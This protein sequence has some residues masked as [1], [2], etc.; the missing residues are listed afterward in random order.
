MLLLLMCFGS[1][2][3]LGEHAASFLALMRGVP[4]LSSCVGAGLSLLGRYSGHIGLDVVLV[5]TTDFV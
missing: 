2:L 5:N 3:T 4:C 1:L